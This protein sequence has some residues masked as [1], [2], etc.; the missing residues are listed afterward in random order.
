MRSARAAFFSCLICTGQHT[1]CLEIGR[2]SAAITLRREVHDKSRTPSFFALH[3]DRSVVQLHN[4]LADGK[5]KAGALR[6]ISKKGAE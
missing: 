4:P 6:L 5:T 2:G 1:W 3:G